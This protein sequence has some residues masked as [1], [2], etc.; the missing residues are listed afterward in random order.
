MKKNVKN[1]KYT[2]IITE[3]STSVKEPAPAA[4]A[5]CAPRITTVEEARADA[6]EIAAA[7]VPPRRPAPSTSAST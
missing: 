4:C 3:A 7:S 6:A 1:S 2:E 5:S